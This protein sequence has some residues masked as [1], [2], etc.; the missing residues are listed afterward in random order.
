M[1][2]DRYLPTNSLPPAIDMRAPHKQTSRIVG[3]KAK[4]VVVEVRS[5][6][7]LSMVGR[8]ICPKGKIF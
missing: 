3:W 4:S 2:S 5:S 8:V 7:E 1:Y 6:I